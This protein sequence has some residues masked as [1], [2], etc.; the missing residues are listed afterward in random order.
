[1]T[2]VPADSLVLVEDRGLRWI[3]SPDSEHG[4]RRGFCGECGSSL[5]WDP[6]ELQT[7]SV[8]AGTL[9]GDPGI[10][11]IGHIWAEQAGGYYELPEDGQP[12]RARGTG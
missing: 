6:P 7:I 12:R 5:F 3:A 9:D 10:R 8:T 2:S 11:T 4:A 1:M